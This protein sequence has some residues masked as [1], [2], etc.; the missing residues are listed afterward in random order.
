M[1]DESR[2]IICEAYFRPNA[3]VGD[4]C[5]VC[6]E[7]Y[8][9]ARSKEEARVTFKPRAKTLSDETVKE[10]IYEIL[11]EAGIKRFECEHCRTLF[12]K[13]SPAQKQCKAC[14]D[15]G[16]KSEKEVK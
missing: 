3:M 6:A 8:P 4:K 11:E 9:K 12:F 5:V 7:L 10:M 15:K 1:T 14:A 2:C 13:T 16:T